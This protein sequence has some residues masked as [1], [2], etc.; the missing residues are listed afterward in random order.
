VLPLEVSTLDER[1]PIEV[2]ELADGTQV[3]VRAIRPDDA[4]RLQALVTRL[5]PATISLRAGMLLKTLSDADASRLARVDYDRSMA[6]VALIGVEPGEQVIGVAR[7]SAVGQPVSDQAETAI[8]VEDAYQRK[9]LARQLLARLAVYAREHG[10][11]SFIA[12]ISAHND[13]VRHMIRSTGL[14]AEYAD[15]GGGERR[16]TISLAQGVP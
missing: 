15:L 2:I 5:S 13:P 9:G 14:P 3:R 1:Y 7:Y 11:R 8:V 12:N 6:L 16:V 10:I 4:P